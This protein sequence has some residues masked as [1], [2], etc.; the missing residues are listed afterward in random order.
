MAAATAWIALRLSSASRW[1]RAAA[2]LALLGLGSMSSAGAWADYVPVTA[3]WLLALVAAGAT[4]E[5]RL[6]APLSVTAL[7]Q[8]TLAGTVPIGEW[9]EP[10]LMT[11]VATVGQL[12]MAAL[13]VGAIAAA[14]RAR[15]SVAGVRAGVEAPP[16]AGRRAA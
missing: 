5:R 4:V 13:F 15:R 11:P 3:V 10:A 12:T 8:V 1:Q 14:T 2:W 7:L 16:D 9:F 6:I